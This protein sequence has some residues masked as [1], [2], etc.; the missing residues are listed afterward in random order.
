MRRLAFASLSFCAAVFAAQYLLPRQ[1][2]LP[3]GALLALAG[4]AAGLGLRGQRRLVLLLVFGGLALGF[5]W[6]W[7]YDAVFYEP[8]RALD[9]RTERLEAVVTDWPR[10]TDYGWS[11]PVRVRLAGKPDV[12]ALLYAPDEAEGLRPGDGLSVIAACRLAERT[13]GGE[14]ITWY[15]A[16]GIF[17]LGTVYGELKAQP[18][19]AVPPRYWPQAAARAMKESLA[20]HAPADTVPFLTA[21]I[22]GDLTDM[23]PD[24]YSALRRAGLVH[25]VVVSGMHVSFVAGLFR[26]L[27]FRRRRL[28]AVG[29][30]VSALLFAAVAGATPSVVRAAFQCV[31]LQLAPLLGREEDAPT[32]LSAVLALLLLQNPMAA[33]SVGLQLSFGAVAGIYLLSPRMQ[34]LF[35]VPLRGKRSLPA[36]VLRTGAGI[37]AATLGAV[38]FTTPLTA[39][40]FGTVSL[41]APLSNLLAYFAVTLAFVLGLFAALAGLILPPLGAALAL[42]AAL[43]ARYL[44][45]LA[46][47]M[48]RIPFASI[49]L[50]SAYYAFWLLF[51]YGAVLL[52]LLGRGGRVRPQMLAG[53][54][55]VLL[56]AAVT[57]TRLTVLSGSLIITVLDVGQGQSV[58]L[59]SKGSAVLVDCGGSGSAGD[60][61]ADWLQNLGE[62]RLDLLVLTHFHADHANGVAALMDRLEVEAVAMPEPEDELGLE[63]VRLAGQ[64]GAQIT[65]IGDQTEL[66]LGEARLLLYPPLGGAGEN[67][68]GLTILCTVGDFDVLITGDMD[69]ATEARLLRGY[70]LPD[71]ELLVVGHH[72]SRYSNSEALLDAVTPEV[73]VISVGRNSYGH[74]AEDT[75]ERLEQRGIAVYRTDLSGAVTITVSP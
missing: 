64:E 24:L 35:T 14:E 74:P 48:G 46:S 28:S 3:A 37:L 60:A 55:G 40:Y 13:K 57:F 23:D 8:A 18:A 58:L 44:L 5:G 56:V 26:L 61:A 9:G 50:A 33:A 15:T 59:Y 22:T 49:T 10:R 31:C 67:E 30:I 63:I 34:R 12:S 51:V 75:L 20:A 47:L 68:Q 73:A 54:C 32:S 27:P 65:C 2:W 21:L 1:L 16:R 29:G 4:F 70:A 72:G 36:R 52:T 53:A 41:V 6:S 7:G 39:W 17:L 43:P 71:I 69:A 38:A 45:V 42:G 11:V 66:A 62:S 25:V 19:G